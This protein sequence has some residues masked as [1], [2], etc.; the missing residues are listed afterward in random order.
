M[1]LL[2][3]DSDRPWPIDLGDDRELTPIDEG[4]TLFALSHK[5]HVPDVIARVARSDATMVDREGMGITLDPCE[6]V[7][8][9]PVSATGF[10]YDDPGLVDFWWDRGALTT[11]QTIGL[12]LDAMDRHA[13]WD[14][15]LL[16]PIRYVR[17]L[18]GGDRALARQMTHDL[19]KIAGAGLLSEVNTYTY[20][21]GD[22]MLST[23][24]LYRPGQSGHQQ[25]IWQAT[26]DE[27]A[28]VF[29]THPGN[30]P[31]ATP[32]A[33]YDPDHYWTGSASLPWAAQ[34]G[35]A[36]IVLYAPAFASPD[37]AGLESS[38]YLEYTH[39]FMPTERFDE[40]HRSNHWTFARRRDAYVALYSW[41]EPHWRHH[42]P[43]VTFTNGLTQPF[44]LVAPGGAHNAWI[45]EVGEATGWG[46]FEEFCA[47]MTAA[48]VTVDVISEEGERSG[49]AA[50]FDS[51]S[52]GILWLSTSGDFCVD[53]ATVDLAHYPRFDN[54]FAHVERGATMVVISD[55]I[56]TLTLDLDRGTRTVT[57]NS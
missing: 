1:K 46:G 51:P 47:A 12:T 21:T 45:V 38:A 53:G 4:S 16:A 31:Y 25:H 57:P 37:I 15:A 10:A 5:Y 27:D 3:H 56:G 35:C 24:Q 49:I 29:T 7:H 8:D 14:V 34:Q 54:P 28:I 11:W 50:T 32:G 18:V 33:I 42:D 22:V 20:R 48:T 9:E 30:E 6:P 23:A 39:A 19:A 40:V 17:D 2:F 36:S 55:E 13:L 41:R 44:D 26:L 43:A 52:Q